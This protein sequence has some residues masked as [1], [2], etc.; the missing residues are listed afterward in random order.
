MDPNE[1]LQTLLDAWSD[2][3][4]DVAQEN[5]DALREW[6]RKGGYVP[7]LTKETLI[8]IVDMLMAAL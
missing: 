4:I 7:T 3:E 2:T 1:C 5:A 8:R 6:L